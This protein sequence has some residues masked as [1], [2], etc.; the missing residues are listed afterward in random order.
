[1]QVFTSVDPL[2]EKY[3]SISP[4][5]YCGGNPVRYID[6]NGEFIADAAGN[7]IFDGG[8]WSKNTPA[9]TLRIANSMSKTP[10]ERADFDFI[11]NSPYPVT[12]NLQSGTNDNSN[13][14]VNIKFAVVTVDGV[15]QSSK[16]SKVDI[17]VSEG[18]AVAT[19][20]K[21]TQIKDGKI[22]VSDLGKSDQARLDNMPKTVDEIIGQKTTH[23][24]GHI[25]Q[26]TAVNE[27]D[28]KEEYPI[29]REIQSVNE[30]LNLIPTPVV[31][32]K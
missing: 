2:A 27:S 20:N 1:M 9:G 21:L 25:R 29:K 28:K 8:K 15:V 31:G 26:S 18:N 22:T 12:L 14:D 7:R 23:E 4:Y 30:N 32:I 13:A 11:A 17:N 10:T 16:I 6:V 19:L 3:Y 24:I 5:A